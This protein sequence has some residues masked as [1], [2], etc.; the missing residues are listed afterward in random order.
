[1]AND[2]EPIFKRGYICD[3]DDLVS[4]IRCMDSLRLKT[5]RFDGGWVTDLIYIPAGVYQL[6]EVW[7]N[8]REDT[9]SAYVECTYLRVPPRDPVYMDFRE[10]ERGYRVEHEFFKVTLGNVPPI[11]GY[12]SEPQTA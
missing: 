3:P 4:L 11:N 1:M 8:Y 6:V 9:P 2:E 5:F 10:F 7:L 12:T